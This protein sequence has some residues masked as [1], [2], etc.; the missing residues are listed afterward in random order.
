MIA[1]NKNITIPSGVT[2]NTNGN[3]ITNKGTINIKGTLNITDTNELKKDPFVIEEG[4]AL[5][6]NSENY[7]SSDDQSIVKVD[8][9]VKVS[10]NDD[11]GYVFNIPTKTT[12]TIN[13][14]N[15]S[16]GK[17]YHHGA[18]DVIEVEGELVIDKRFANH[19]TI[20]VKT[21]GKLTLK[22][23]IF[24]APTNKTGKLIF[25]NGANLEFEDNVKIE[26]EGAPA[27]DEND[28]EG[29]YE[30]NGENN[31]WEKNKN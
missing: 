12:A 30:W 11:N 21:N 23:N 26:G 31:K 1:E 8:G 18:A 15:S 19:G 28:F 20:D 14:S 29:T 24:A 7:V 27:P 10:S 13:E 9:P 6:L 3:T 5:T 25:A 2:L 22:E 16:S 17:Y 4:G